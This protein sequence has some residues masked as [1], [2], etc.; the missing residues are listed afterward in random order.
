[1]VEVFTENKP[2]VPFAGGQHP[3][4]AL[5]ARA[6]EPMCLAGIPC[7]G[8]GVRQVAAIRE[9]SLIAAL[10]GGGGCVTGGQPGD[11]AQGVVGVAHDRDEI[12]Y[13]VNGEG[14]V[15]QE[16]REPDPHAAWQ[17]VV[18]SQRALS[19]GVSQGTRVSHLADWLAL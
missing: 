5:A 18:N 15:G 11:P 2:E 19:A 9:I 10:P 6:G 1:L 7:P 14:T 17:A 16:Q 12:R 3:V 4:Q 13:Q 8:R